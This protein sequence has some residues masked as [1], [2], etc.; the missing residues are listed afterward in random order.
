MILL[1]VADVELSSPSG[2]GALV[3][4][5]GLPFHF[6]DIISAGLSLRVD[7][8][9]DHLD[10]QTWISVAAVCSSWPRL[11]DAAGCEPYCRLRSWN[12]RL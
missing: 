8:Q 12:R 1:A 3:V 7:S 4:S 9:I 10:E 6:M 5:H 11:P 2:P